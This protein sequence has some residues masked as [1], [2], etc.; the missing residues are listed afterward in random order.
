[1]KF[2]LTL[3]VVL[4]VLWCVYA[5]WFD[6]RRGTDDKAWET[7]EPATLA[8]EA[9]LTNAQ[10]QEDLDFLL[11][12]VAER[13]PAAYGGLPPEVQAQYDEEIR[14]LGSEVSV[15]E[16]YRASARILTTLHDSHTGISTLGAQSRQLP[17]GFSFSWEGGELILAEASYAGGTDIVIGGVRQA[18]RYAQYKGRKV[19]LLAGVSPPE[20]YERYKTVF[21]VEMEAYGQ[22][23]FALIIRYEEYLELLGAE[24]LETNGLPV[25]FEGDA[26]PVDLPLSSPVS[27]DDADGSGDSGGDPAANPSFYYELDEAASLG[28]LT[29][30]ACEMSQAYKDTL[31]DF[32]AAVRDRGI[33]NVALDLR[34]NGGGTTEVIGEFMRY[35][36]VESYDTNTFYARYGPLRLHI[37][38]NGQKNKMA[39]DLVFTG[40]LF[41]L[42]NVWTWSSATNFAA[43]LKYNSLAEIVGAQ[44]GND[45]VYGH[46][47][48]FQL[49]HSRLM[50]T[51]SCKAYYLGGEPGN[52]AWTVPDHPCPASEAMDKVRE[53][54]ASGNH[55]A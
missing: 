38:G 28:I 41:V 25:L 33:R 24:P 22:A 39:G 46:I 49:P 52:A 35:M 19:A 31:R 5:L 18:E 27:G 10:A 34:G 51:V 3:A 6:P 50:M 45:Q 20:L 4:A 7:G 47:L 1:M 21:P 53:L 9:T 42:T 26:E 12:R 29:V 23:Q 44:S 37:N 36:P 55:A 17:Q 11:K 16:V 40:R 48:C 13:H 8:L 14:A 54:I 15:L 43:Y 30:E 2:A 32:F